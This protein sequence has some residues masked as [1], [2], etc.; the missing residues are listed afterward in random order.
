MTKP[1]VNSTD[2]NDIYIGEHEDYTL[3]ADKHGYISL[4]FDSESTDATC[5]HVW[6]AEGNE[7]LYEDGINT[8]KAYQKKVNEALKIAKGRALLLGIKLGTSN[9]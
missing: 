7:L 4:Y 1:R 2:R 3:Y 8:P 9:E 6:M 5:Y